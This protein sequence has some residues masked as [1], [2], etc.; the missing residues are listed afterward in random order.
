[1]TLHL[2]DEAE[3]PAAGAVEDIAS[4]NAMLAMERVTLSNEAYRITPE[5]EPEDEPEDEFLEGAFED[6]S[7][8]FGQL[9]D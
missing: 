1:M 7:D 5:T 8:P 2:Y 4:I 3:L 9:D 6:L